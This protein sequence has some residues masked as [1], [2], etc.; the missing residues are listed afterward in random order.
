MYSKQSLLIIRY[1]SAFSIEIR[2]V[3]LACLMH[4]YMAVEHPCCPALPNEDDGWDIVSYISF[5]MVAHIPS[6][7][8]DR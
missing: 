6:S 5:K 3:A 4:L 1:T 8:I 7:Q 2:C